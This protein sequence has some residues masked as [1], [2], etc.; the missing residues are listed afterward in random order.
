MNLL[1]LLAAAQTAT[2]DPT[3][4]T[5]CQRQAD[6]AIYG[7]EGPSCWSCA[8]EY[9]E[10]ALVT[11]WHGP[12]QHVHLGHVLIGTVREVGRKVWRAVSTRAGTAYADTRHA[13]ACALLTLWGDNT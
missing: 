9:P 12:A 3:A 7:D 4:C 1:D 6:P 8:V 11:V 5:Y 10:R 2:D 13:A